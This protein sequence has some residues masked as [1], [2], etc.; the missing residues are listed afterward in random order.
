MMTFNT[1]VYGKWILAGE[2]SVIRGYPALVFPVKNRSLTF[3]YQDTDDIFSIEHL[4]GEYSI[5]PLLWNKAFYQAKKTLGMENKDFKGKCS[6]SSTIPL[7]AG[8]GASAALCVSM[9]RFFQ[10][11]GYLAESEI[12]SF[13]RKLEN[14]FH[15]TSSGVDI[16]AAC[17]GEGILFENKK[18]QLIEK[19]W[20]PKWY[21]YYSGRQAITSE[22]VQK[23]ARL[24]EKD[25]VLGKKIDESMAKSVELA[26]Q[27]LQKTNAE[28]GFPLLVE[29]TN[30][31]A[32]CFEQWDL[33]STQD[34]EKMD[35]L[36]TQGCAAVK[37]TGSG[38]GGHLLT[39][40]QEEPPQSLHSQ[41]IP[42]GGTENVH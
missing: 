34:K 14:I 31:A 37:P 2:H 32:S 17:T 1:T 10:W 26:Q 39:L 3:S 11:K 38:G 16:A 4:D 36:F 25:K 40:W 8:L 42:C 22:S 41:L 6:L 12:W 5:W 33:I 24:W 20:Q 28:E 13:A 35:Y 9:A 23:V 27:S 30:R 18:Y 15:G 29:A 7:G 19:N 21:L